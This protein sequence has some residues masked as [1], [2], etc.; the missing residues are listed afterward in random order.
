MKNT[1]E[2]LK[3]TN[4]IL[5]IILIILL[6]LT[7]LLSL[8][9]ALFSAQSTDNTQIRIGKIDVIIEEDWP[10][11]GQPG[12]GGEPYD[13]FGIKKYAKVVN[14][15]SLGDLPAYVRIRCI[16]IVQYYYIPEG[17]TEGEWFT[18]NV[19]QEDIV[20][21]VSGEDWIRDG[22]Y[23][24][25]TKILEGYGTK[26]KLNINWELSE[27]PSQIEN[28]DIRVDVRVILE[29]AQTTNNIWKEVFKIEELPEG[30]EIFTP[31]QQETV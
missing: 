24:Y 23:Y 18:A 9:Y 13:E 8:V 5:L 10:E 12:D 14:G 28:Y 15:K 1:Q 4:K 25:Y 16:P 22:E 2:N 7:L 19:A 3:R 21:W 17:K 27:I 6:V 31:E 20:L 26:G 30:V 29:Y 11:E